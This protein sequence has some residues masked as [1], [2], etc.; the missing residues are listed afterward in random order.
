MKFRRRRRQTIR[1]MVRPTRHLLQ[2]IHSVSR[3][4][5]SLASS[6]MRSRAQ[7][8]T[9]NLFL[10]KQLA[11]NQERKVKPGAPMTRHG[12]SSLAC[13][14]PGVASGAGRREAG[15]TDPLASTG[16][17]TVLALEVA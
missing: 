16:I 1:F 4:L 2:T 11:L 17:P 6:A 10:R 9:E 13:R 8:A 15:D 7:L 12:S 5:V 3:A 14:V